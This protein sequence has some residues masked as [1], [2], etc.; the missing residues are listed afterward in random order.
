M[1]KD[2]ER[3]RS[4]YAAALVAHFGDRALAVARTQMEGAADGALTEWTALTALLEAQLHA[5]E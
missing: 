1:I 5:T 2:R 4:D 3:L